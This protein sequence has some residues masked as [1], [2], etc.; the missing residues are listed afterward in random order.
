[1]LWRM[2]WNVFLHEWKFFFEK[3]L[4]SENGKE[5]WVIPVDVHSAVGFCA[6]LSW[7]PAG[8]RRHW[9]ADVCIEK[10]KVHPSAFI[11]QRWHNQK[12]GLD[13]H[14]LS[15]CNAWWHTR[16][17]SILKGISTQ[18]QQGNQFEKT[19]LCF[20]PFILVEQPFESLEDWWWMDLFCSEAHCIVNTAI[21]QEISM[22]TASSNVWNT[23]V[24][25]SE[26]DINH[27]KIH[28]KNKC[29][30]NGKINHGVQCEPNNEFHQNI[31]HN[32]TKSP[33]ADWNLLFQWNVTLFKF[34]GD[35]NLNCCSMEFAMINVDWFAKKQS[36]WV[37]INQV[38]FAHVKVCLNGW[39]LWS[40]FW[41]RLSS[42]LIWVQTQIA[43]HGSLQ[44]HYDWH[45][46][47]AISPSQQPGN[48]GFEL[49]AS[50]YLFSSPNRK[51]CGQRHKST[52][53]PFWI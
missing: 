22:K 51:R 35:R 7:G 21:N 43:P 33:M 2:F 53:I 44:A 52:I 50:N 47:I 3:V 23:D 18:I 29:D 26:T 4:M 12:V 34:S 27:T 42:W 31:A 14:W 10:N 49:V 30:W 9:L 20:N 36:I 6:V 46:W 17:H 28:I 11:P 15:D 24:E 37:R 39:L 41:I 13:F 40:S 8:A 16:C 38:W 1:M 48:Q 19:Q 25:L 5:F 45:S 32:K